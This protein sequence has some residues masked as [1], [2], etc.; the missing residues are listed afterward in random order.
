VL[1]AE[2]AGAT[3]ASG[4]A[5]EAADAQDSQATKDSVVTGVAI[6]VFWPDPCSMSRSAR[7][8]GVFVAAGF[9]GAATPVLGII[10]GGV[11]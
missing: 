5:A 8:A 9:F 11:G 1:A 3:D 7:P 2:V 10:N 6:V 4:T